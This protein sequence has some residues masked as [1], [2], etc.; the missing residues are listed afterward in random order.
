MCQPAELEKSRT[1]AAGDVM[2]QAELERLAVQARARITWGESQ[3][4]VR[5]WLTTE[6]ITQPWTDKILDL[7]M[8]ER[9]RSIRRKGLLR[10][11][12]GLALVVLCGGY[13][14]YA[15]VSP[16]AKPGKATLLLLPAVLFGIHLTFRGI[17]LLLRGG[18]VRGPLN[19]VN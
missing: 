18:R 14:I 19:D 3:A 8:A 6:G 12:V 1:V 15:F 16:S 2:S 10:L 7:A 4:S 9:S 5:D 13:L 11:L 17:E